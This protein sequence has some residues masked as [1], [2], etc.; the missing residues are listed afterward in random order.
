[1][2]PTSVHIPRDL[3]QK[4]LASAVDAYHKDLEYM[5]AFSF[6]KTPSGFYIKRFYQLDF[7]L[8][9]KAN[10]TFKTNQY[11]TL[12]K[13]LRGQNRFYGTIHTHIN[14]CQESTPSQIDWVS[15][16]KNYKE[17]LIGICSLWTSNKRIK[18]SINYWLPTLPCRKVYI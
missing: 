2:N 8:Q 3:Q 15:A 17:D 9:T 7:D 18:S 6:E 16:S 4:F 1:M 11:L 13:N 12:R 14:V 5:E 10:I